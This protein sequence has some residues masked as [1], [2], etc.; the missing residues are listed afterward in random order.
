MVTSGAPN[1]VIPPPTDVVADKEEEKDQTNAVLSHRSCHRNSRR[2]KELIKLRHDA[3]ITADDAQDRDYGICP[4]A[5]R[6]TTD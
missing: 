2:G 6:V 1:P 5:D 3:Y 4:P